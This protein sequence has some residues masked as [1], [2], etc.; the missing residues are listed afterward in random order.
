M[1]IPYTKLSEE[2]LRGIIEE[3][4]LREGTE[5]GRND[6]AVETKVQQVK[7]QLL[8]GTAVIVFDPETDSCDVRVAQ[9]VKEK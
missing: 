1:I 5:Y 6:V 7:N 9:E 4:V 2:V 3:F 8:K